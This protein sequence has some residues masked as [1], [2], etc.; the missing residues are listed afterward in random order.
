MF[1]VI[2]Q[3]DALDTEVSEVVSL[4]RSAKNR[5]AP[6]NRLPRDV[7]VL[8]PD[9][10]DGLEREKI[11]IVLTHVCRAWREL[12]ISLASLWTNFRC[13]DAD[14]TRSYLERS[15]SALLNSITHASEND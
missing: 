13:V 10:W 14:E 8:I 12:F 2:F 1:T 4:I 5:R 15:K 6:I 7:L 11:A 9:F 3:L